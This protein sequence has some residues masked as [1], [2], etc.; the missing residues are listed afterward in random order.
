MREDLDPTVVDAEQLVRLVYRAHLDRVFGYLAHRLG[1][2]RADAE[3]LTQDVF[4]AFVAAVRSGT[5]IDDPQGWLITVARNKLVDHLRRAARVV[6]LRR[7]RPDD[8]IEMVDG[9]LAA[10]TML[11]RLPTMQR[12]AMVLRYVDDLAVPDVAGVLGKS[13]HATESLLARARKTLAEELP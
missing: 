11:E 1:G 9:V 3:E 7:P 5:E 8:R 13:V 2:R 10:A 12:A 4:L 6:P